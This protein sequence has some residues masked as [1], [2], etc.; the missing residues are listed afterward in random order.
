[1]VVCVSRSTWYIM[2]IRLQ[3]ATQK[4]RGVQI[5]VMRYRCTIQKYIGDLEVSRS[6]GLL[7]LQ[8]SEH[9]RVKS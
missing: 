5:H 6:G 2:Q 1:M 7:Y 3:A 9:R 8:L 4:A